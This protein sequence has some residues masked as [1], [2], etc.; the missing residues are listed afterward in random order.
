M[1]H[2]NHRLELFFGKTSFAFDVAI[3]SLPGSLVHLE[4]ETFAASR[5]VFALGQIGLQ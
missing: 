5:A 2:L 3:G 4:K 1:N